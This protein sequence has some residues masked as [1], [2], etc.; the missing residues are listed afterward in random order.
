MKHKIRI[1]KAIAISV[2]VFF[3]TDTSLAKNRNTLNIRKNKADT[4]SSDLFQ[5]DII[6][7]DFSGTS[8][9]TS[10]KSFLPRHHFI[11]KIGI[12]ARPGHIV[13]SHSFLQGE[14]E[15]WKPIKNSFSTHLK[16][17]FQS[18]PNTYTDRIFGGAYQGIGLAYYTFGEKKSLGEPIAFYLFQGARITRLCYQLSLNYE[19]NFGLSAGW[20]PYDRNYN[21]YNTIIGSK[22]NAYINTNFYLNWMLSRRFDLTAGITLTHFSNGNTRFP[23]A[24]LNTVGIKAGLIYNINRPNRYI[25]KSSFRPPIP[26]FPRHI[27]YDLVLFG[28]WRRKGVAFGEEHIASPDAYTVLGFNFA[29]MYN[30]GYKFRAGLSLDG[31]YDGSA[32]I[33]TDDYYSYNGPNFYKPAFNKQIALGISGRTEFVMPY[34]SVNLGM[35]LNMLHGGGDLKAFYQILALK[36]KVTRNSFIHIGYSLQNFDTPNFLMLGIGL[37]FNNKYPYLYH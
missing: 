24:G 22:V 28:S 19:W 4:L 9:L 32:N 13:Q 11:H 20:E 25:A 6:P 35:G 21:Y 30:L 37:R 12:E 34:F 10:T 26:E 36:I 3:F 7:D 14:N 33:Y 15:K 1:W 8:S 29:P 2:I 16:Y 18:H 23:N 27:S 5:E 17:S 31:F